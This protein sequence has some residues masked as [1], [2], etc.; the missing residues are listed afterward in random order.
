METINITAYTKNTT[1]IN[2]IKSFMKALKIK[3]ELNKQEKDISQFI[4]EIQSSLNQVQ[5]IK[6]GKR[7]KQT[8]KEFLDDL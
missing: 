6:L 3:F 4:S 2:A 8:V 5:E 7:P 1:E